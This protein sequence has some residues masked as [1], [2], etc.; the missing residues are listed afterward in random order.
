MVAHDVLFSQT[1]VHGG[2]WRPVLTKHCLCWLM[3]SCSHKALFMVAHDVLF[4]QTTVYV[5]S[6]RPVL[7]NHCICWLM[8]SCF[9][10]AL[11][12][13]AHYVLFSQNTVYVGSWRPVPTNHCLCWLMK[14]DMMN[15]SSAKSFWEANYQELS[16]SATQNRVLF[17][18]PSLTNALLM[19]ATTLNFRIWVPVYTLPS[20]TI[21][22]CFCSWKIRYF[23]YPRIFQTIY[24]WCSTN[25]S[26]EFY[27]WQERSCL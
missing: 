4:S 6:R 22:L 26:P 7:T 25:W 2:S 12:I 1:T 15:S 8:T 10:K 27:F 18:L 13:V 3:T 5:G 20:N 11:F 16:T 21:L 17:W 23:K 24:F 9:H 14:Q 19:T